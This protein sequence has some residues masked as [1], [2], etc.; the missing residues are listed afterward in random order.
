MEHQNSVGGGYFKGSLFNH[1]IS[2][3]NLFEALKEFKSGKTGKLEIQEFAFNLEDN[4]F[5]LHTELKEKIW[6]PDPYIA[7]YVRDPKLRHIHKATVRDRVF[8]QALFR[9]LYQIFD[10]GF[11]SDSYSCRKEKGTHRGVLKLESYIRKISR[12]YTKR[13][14]ALKCDVR[15]FFDNIDHEILSDLIKKRITDPDILSLIRMILGS[16]ET[17]PGVGLPL[18]NVTSQFFANVYLNELDQF[19]KHGIKT[20]YYLRYCDD[21]IILGTDRELLRKYVQSIDVFLC[22]KLHLFLHPH[23]IIIRKCN[24]GIDFL[25]YVVLPEHIVLRTKTKK[26]ILKKFRLLQA[27][28][29]RNLITL[30]TFDSTKHSYLGMLTHCDGYK[31]KQKL[32]APK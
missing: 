28:F 8:N 10:K 19:A 7:F 24:Q 23:K 1:V 22:D 6:K 18:G 13:S 21:F 14:F 9:I 5:K 30:K 27:R 29:D 25:G 16:F 17:K 12:N 15:K 3:E 11:I 2:L 20:K 32:I 31:I 26:R 4:I